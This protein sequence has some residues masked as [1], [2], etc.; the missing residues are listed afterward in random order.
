MKAMAPV[1]KLI[2]E[3]QADIG[4]EKSEVKYRE[5]SLPENVVVI[6]Q[7]KAAATPLLE[8]KLFDSPKVSK[9]E[10]KDIWMSIQ[11]EIIEEF[12][13]KL[14]TPERDAAKT[15]KYLESLF[16]S[17]FY[18]F[19]EELVTKAI[20]D[21]DQ[22]LDGRKLDEIRTLVSEVQ[23]FPRVHGSGLFSRGETQIMSILTLGS[24]GDKVSIETMELDEEKRYFHHY[25]MLPFSVGDVKPLRGAGRREIGHGALAEKALSPVI[26]TEQEF[27]YTIR[28][29]SEVMSSNGSSSMGATCGS[30]L[31]LLDAGVPIK[32]HV[33]GIAIGLASNGDKW[34][35]LTDMQ[36]LEDG[37]GG[38]DFKF[39]GTKD[40]LTAVQMD[41][42]TKGLP[43]EIIKATFPQMRKALDEVIDSMIKVIPASNAGLSPYAPR[44]LMVKIDPEKIGEVI[45][46]GGKVIRAL[47]EEFDV[48]IDVNDAGEVYITSVNAGGATKAK[49]RIEDIVREIKVGEIFENAEVVKVLDFGAFIKLTPNKDGMLHISEID[50]GRTPKVTDKVNVGDKI[51]VKV[52]KIERGKIEVSLRALTP[53]P[54]GYVE[55]PPRSRSRDSRGGRDSRDSRGRG[56]DRR[57][58]RGRPPS[59]D[60]GSRDD[61]RPP[62][63]SRPRDSGSK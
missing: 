37:P 1:V 18:E 31:A 16:R 44:I 23:L 27:P 10:R 6:D 26:P 33:G 34:K 30:T 20:L 59:R 54:E 50:W 58:S 49:K 24:P 42:K 12:S 29:V 53:K 40:G 19:I 21:K 41:T 47:T 17:F 11:K 60:R 2:T 36:D 3:I 61:R 38:M 7:L 28:V 14:A 51:T 13:E 35:I 46:P 25:N 57:D 39:T 22:R 5:S 52:I 8:K 45:G 63:D 62:R 32:K 43:I 56:G 9:G 15:G 48:Q 55:P 4:K